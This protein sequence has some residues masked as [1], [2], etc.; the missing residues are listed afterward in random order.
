MVDFLCWCLRRRPNCVVAGRDVTL[1]ETPPPQ[2]LF[3]LDHQPHF[4][5]LRL[6]QFSRISLSSERRELTI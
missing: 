5:P 2:S 3:L 1:L 4:V 6:S